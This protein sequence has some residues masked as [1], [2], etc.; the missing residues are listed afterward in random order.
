MQAV[1]EVSSGAQRGGGRW[2]RGGGGGGCKPNVGGASKEKLVAGQRSMALQATPRAQHPQLWRRRSRCLTPKGEGGGRGGQVFTVSL[3]TAV[4]TVGFPAQPRGNTAH[5]GT[6]QPGGRVE[7]VGR[8]LPGQ[9]TISDQNTAQGQLADM[10]N[11]D[12]TRGWHS[13]LGAM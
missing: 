6:K 8:S 7:L 4:R 11:H 9:H 5:L 12:T 1:A 2:A 10:H 3:R 13:F